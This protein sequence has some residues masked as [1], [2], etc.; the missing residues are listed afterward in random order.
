MAVDRTRELEEKLK[1]LCVA[2]EDTCVFWEKRDNTRFN[3]QTCYY[4]SHYR[5]R[6]S[7]EFTGICSYK[8]F[9]RVFDLSQ[10]RRIGESDET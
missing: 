3:V 5:A 10:F 8:K 7:D 2:S 6:N 4:C 9:E 1:A